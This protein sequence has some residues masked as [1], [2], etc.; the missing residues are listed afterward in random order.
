MKIFVSVPTRSLPGW[1]GRGAA[2]GLETVWSTL[3]LAG[4]PPITGL[5]A[6]QMSRHCTIRIDKIR[7]ELGYAPLISVAEGLRQLAGA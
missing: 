4:E 7:R 2:S 3:R 5:A 1:L 6:G